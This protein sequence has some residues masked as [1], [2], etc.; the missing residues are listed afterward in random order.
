MALQRKEDGLPRAGSRLA[1]SA[2]A[3]CSPL[4]RKC[5]GLRPP[6]FRSAWFTVRLLP[7]ARTLRSGPRNDRT[8]GGVRDMELASTL[9][10]LACSRRPASLRLRADR[11]RAGPA[12]E[13]CP[14]APVH[15]GCSRRLGRSAPTYNIY[16]NAPGLDG[17]EKPGYTRDRKRRCPSPVSPSSLL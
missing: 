14:F 15:P 10:R 2:T 16:A 13:L 7:G 6:V 4:R 11:G 17:R 3:H 12:P 8:G 5:R 1:P 9:S